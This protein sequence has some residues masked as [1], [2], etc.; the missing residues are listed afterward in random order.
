MDCII[1]INNSYETIHNSIEVL[2]ITL[3][4]YLKVD[5]AIYQVLLL[6]GVLMIV[7]M[8]ITMVIFNTYSKK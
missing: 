8:L 4:I 6:L 3:L 2:F 1:F 7:N 5:N